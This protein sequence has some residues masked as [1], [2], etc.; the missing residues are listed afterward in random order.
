MRV[1]V[2]GSG[3]VGLVTAACLAEKGHTAVCVDMD[4]EKVGRINRREAPIYEKGLPELLA[5]HVP[6]RL[7]AT[8]DLEQAILDSELTLIAVG[9]PFDG[10][11]IDL[12]A[13]RKAAFAIGQALRHKDS[14]HVVTV[15][16][17]VVPGTTDQ[18]VC[19]ELEAGSGKAAGACFG[20][21]V[22]PEFLT[23][24]EAVADFMCP[25]RIVIG[26]IDER[27]IEMVDRL[28]V[29]F[30]NVEII[31]TN[32]R[33]AEMIKYASNA[34][35]ATAISFANEIGNL[36]A[37]LGG[38]DVTD[39]LHGVHRSK[40]LSLP[41]ANGSATEAPLSRFVEAGCGFGGSCLPKDVSA[42]IAHAKQVGLPMPLLESVI[43]TNRRQPERLLS[44]LKSHFPSL[45]G[46]RVVVLGLAFKPDTSDV[47]ESSA[48]IVIRRLVDEGAIV[49][50]YD[51]V[52][53]DEARR[54]LGGLPVE[55][56][57]N[58]EEAVTCVDAAV[59]ITRWAQFRQLPEVVARLSSPPLVIDGRRMLDKRTL[60]RYAGIGLS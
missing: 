23:E 34:L 11:Q 47:R 28:Y 51:P 3:Y 30:P 39:V 54:V 17:T 24:G 4:A 13:I 58:L 5:A 45:S 9:T 42:L 40:Y 38:I 14:Y 53:N 48:L 57:D 21:A 2:V 33:T 56:C 25:D 29:G 7:T 10:T 59:L 50:A 6:S 31:R 35:L 37:A 49:R 41:G 15:K 8:T 26:G 18:V 22:N 44:I 52:A 46:L 19:R 12:T 1:S 32:T 60:P 27:S 20:L 55:Y 16:S 43:Q 36:C